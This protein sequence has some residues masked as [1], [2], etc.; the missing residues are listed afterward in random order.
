MTRALSLRLTGAQVLRPDGLG[1]GPVAIADG[2][3]VDAGSRE[4][5]ASG[6]MI[7]PGIIDLHGDGFEHHMAPRRGAQT[8]PQLG[9]RAVE[10]ELA[11]NGITTAVLAQFFS[12][13][14]GM[15]GPDFAEALIA[16]V[17]AYS[18]ALDLRIQLRFELSLLEEFD[19]VKALIEREKIGYVVLNDHLNHTALAAGK[20]PPRLVGQ[21]LKSGRSPEDHMALLTRLHEQTPAALQALPDLT[22]WMAERGIKI[23]SHD[24]ATPEGRAEFRAMG[25]T[26][27]EFPET[28]AA[29]VAAKAAGDAVIMGAPNVVRGGS[30]DGKIA[31]TELIADGLVDALVSDYH[32][33]APHRAALALW[34]KGMAL[35]DAWALISG[36]PAQVMGWTDR[37]TI[38]AGKRADLIV[39][40]AKTHRIEGVF[41]AGRAAHL[42]GAFAA[43]LIGG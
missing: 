38:E 32:Y 13:E 28:R 3:I 26:I 12:W 34:G 24:D 21:A 14:G 10:A 19:R 9:L 43:R 22:A 30:H 39:M 40:E 29:A 20:R 16:A 7:L 15:R 11:A 36:G 23:G 2:V 25:A 35:H 6:Y 8:N 18:A 42:S 31:A 27:A 33:P 17:G 4:V 5:D 41:C 37:G 1:E